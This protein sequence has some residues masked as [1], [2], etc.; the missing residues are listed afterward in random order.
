ML[1]DY[2]IITPFSN[3]QYLT[4][5][6]DVIREI[7]FI[8][9]QG[10]FLSIRNAFPGQ[11]NKAGTWLGTGWSGTAGDRLATSWGRA[12]YAREGVAGAGLAAGSWIETF[13]SH[14]LAG[15]AG[16]KLLLPIGPMRHR[17][18]KY[19]PLGSS[20]GYYKRTFPSGKKLPWN[21]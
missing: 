17:W 3:P 19:P 12:S 2:R 15:V 4:E 6:P 11:N 9:S 8:L 20:H 5:F 21:E 1:Q 16:A 10:F 7:H 18:E 13:S 14:E